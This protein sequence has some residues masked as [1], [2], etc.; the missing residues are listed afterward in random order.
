MGLLML[1]TCLGAGNVHAAEQ[2]TTSVAVAG[3]A[4]GTIQAT[5]LS[6]NQT[7]G[8]VGPGKILAR[9]AEPL[10]D[11]MFSSDGK[12]LV[13]LEGVEGAR[14]LFLVDIENPAPKRLTE[15]SADRRS[16]SFSSDGKTVFFAEKTG[17]TVE[18]NV[19]GNAEGNFD[20]FALQLS[21]G[22][23]RALTK[24]PEDEFAAIC[25]P[26]RFTQEYQEPVASTY[27][28]VFYLKGKPGAGELW[29]LSEDGSSATRLLEGGFSSF[30]LGGELTNLLL[31]DAKGISLSGFLPLMDKRMIAVESPN[32]PASLT[33]TVGLT[34]AVFAGNRTNLFAKKGDSLVVL[35]EN[36]GNMRVISDGVKGRA[37]VD[38]TGKIIVCVQQDN[39]GEYQLV[40]RP[41]NDQI[42]RITNLYKW[43][44]RN[45]EKITLSTGTAEMG[46]LQKQKFFVSP[47]TAKMFFQSYENSRYLW[48]ESYI[49]ADAVLHLFHLYYDFALKE[50]EKSSFRD[51]MFEV[52]VA[53]EKQAQKA[54]SAAKKPEAKELFTKWRGFFA[55]ASALAEPDVIQAKKRLSGLPAAMKKAAIQDIESVFAATS[56]VP[57]VSA[58]LKREVDFT[59]F[60]VRGHYD[61]G[62]KLESY[63]RLMM[64]FSQVP[65]NVFES[66]PEK[67][68]AD[69]P[70]ILALYHLGTTARMGKD[71]VLTVLAHI[72][73]PLNYLVG[74][75]E[76][77]GVIDLE[78]LLTG[79]I[80]ITTP[81][82]VVK[83]ELATAAV[84]AFKTFPKPRIRPFNEVQVLFFPQRFTIDSYIMQ[85]LVYRAVGTPDKPRMLPNMLDVPAA[86]GSDRAERLLLDVLQQGDFAKYEE[87]L[88]AVRK[89]VTGYPAA[90]WEGN[91]YRGWLKA[92]SDLW[93]S[94]TPSLPEF[95][96]SDAWTDRLLNTGLG[97]LTTLRHDTLLYNKMGAAEA[98][99][100]GEEYFIRNLP[101]VYVEPYPELFGR[102]RRMTL[103][104]YAKMSAQGFLPQGEKIKG[105]EESYD[106]VLS[107]NTKGLTLNLIA[108]LEMLENAS[109]KQLAGIPLD[110]KEHAALLEFGMTLEHMTI[111]F[112]RPDEENYNII[113]EELSLIA[114]V[115]NGDGTCLEMAIGRVFNLWVLVGG[116]AGE[117]LHRGG[118]FSY[119]EFEQPISKR[120]N[121]REWKKLIR[122]GDL[123]K[124]PVWTNSFVV[125]ELPRLTENQDEEPEETGNPE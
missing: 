58:I 124:L 45:G 25:A 94:A 68:S 111:A 106:K 79:K 55:V 11:P 109:K 16:P 71:S 29:S 36:G 91:L 4:T 62:P 122:Q 121:D 32:L 1:F 28:K 43:L 40:A 74:E 42:L 70:V 35:D 27:E 63:F 3:S 31:T 53:L 38:P 33:A 86:M 98:G 67:I 125:G 96:R 54:E 77:I 17:G 59:Q 99:E 10:L 41:V 80:A 101:G 69:I 37:A 8:I 19:G 66:D 12:K 117:K 92:L 34:D 104:L 97:S 118:V 88:K 7:D 83:P 64:W 72:S 56:P 60:K 18:G 84:T 14:R 100:G 76:D 87:T 108:V 20:L 75:T 15:K 57:P 24:T 85:R 95:A 114:D 82:D 13:W 102:L 21:D 50:I 107:L 65:L 9:S 90:E 81:D 51:R 26:G 119:F 6:I 113:E 116:P 48:R 105:R 89:E 112:M 49:T 78:R 44:P 2:A 23:T 123:P 46:I 39:A 93:A 103:E 47:D 52:A 22:K 73:S 120:L 5:G 30:D 115:F 110:E 61:G